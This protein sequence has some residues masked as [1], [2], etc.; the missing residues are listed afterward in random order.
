MSK[1]FGRNRRR[2]MREALAAEQARGQKLEAARLMDAGLLER[3]RERLDFLHEF[4]DFVAREVGRDSIFAGEPRH[5]GGGH[6]RMRVSTYQ[7][8]PSRWNS[9]VPQLQAITSEVLRLLE[10]DAIRDR[11]A[12]QVHVRV[13][14]ADGRVGY[15]ISEKAL[16]SLKPGDLERLLLPQVAR[17][18]TRALVNVIKRGSL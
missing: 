5:L 13:G 4:L 11:M 2:R 12:N 1:R 18:I 15:A 10:V 3:Q 17:D 8:I 14:L 9:P 16:A 7:P 6:D